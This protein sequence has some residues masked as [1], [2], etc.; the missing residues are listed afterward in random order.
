MIKAKIMK[1]ATFNIQ[2]IFHRDT[3]LVKRFREE[4]EEVWVKEFESLMFK[5]RPN[6]KD[7]SRMRELAIL[8]GFHKPPYE[9][10]LSMRRKSG[11]LHI[12]RREVFREYKANHITDWNGWIKLRSIPI[13]ETSIQNKAMVINEIDPD[14]LILQE[15]EDRTSLLNFNKE[16]LSNGDT[17]KYQQIVFLETNDSYGRGMGIL[18]KD[19]Y[20]IQS[21]KTH[22]ND[23]D[24]NGNSLFDFDVQEY[25]IR[26]PS[27]ENLKLL[28][29]HLAEGALDNE[30]SNKKRK[31]QSRKIA[32]I[33]KNIMKSNSLVA[34]IGSLNTPSFSDSIS[35]LLKDTDLKDITRHISFNTG[36]DEDKKSNDLH[37]MAYKMGIDI[38]QRNYLLLSPRLF[39]TVKICGQFRKAIWHKVQMQGTIYKAIQKEQHAASKFP[40]IWAEF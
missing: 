17:I 35:P 14:I 32:D 23:L 37:V 38:K 20:Q 40:F 15:V 12:Q 30:E 8:L 1:I 22:V 25:E 24:E 2:N 3:Y 26:T 16:F 31:I 5:Y 27:G 4:N 29:A 39:K 34:V 11:Q 13:N 36:L 6:E 18:A 28:A 10:F 9:P 21:I 33:Y 7:Y 19:G